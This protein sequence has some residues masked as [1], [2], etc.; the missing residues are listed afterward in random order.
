MVDSATDSGR[1]LS[2]F[3]GG[4]D[5]SYALYCAQQRGHEI[6]ALVTVLPAGESYMYQ[7]P[8]TTLTALAAESLGYDL[9]T[10]S[11]APPE[12][13]PDA[14]TRGDREIE[15]L[16]RLLQDLLAKES[17]KGLITGAIASTFQRDRLAALCDRLGLE[18]VAPLWQQ[19]PQKTAAGLFDAG[20]EITIVEVAAG[21][22]D[23][24]WLGR[25][26]DREAFAEL[27]TLQ[28]Q[29]GI[30]PLGEG[31][32][33]ETFVTNGPHMRHPITLTY[34]IEWDGLRGNLVITDCSFDDPN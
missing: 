3:S 18:L 13:T 6:G 27:L 26:L 9:H 17:V 14:S 1:W 7:R 19:A 23:R 28:E 24:S 10:V 5:S 2:L 33:F 34:D 21:G 11:L 29:H 15:P 22:L 25:Q 16:E 31:G 12:G 32:E 20:F 30:H 8:D 4:K